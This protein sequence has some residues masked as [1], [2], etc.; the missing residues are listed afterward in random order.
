MSDYISPL[1]LVLDADAL[2]SNYRWLSNESGSA[3]CGAAVK[4]DGYGLGARGVV[5]QLAKAGCRDFFVAT[6]AEA[7]ALGPMHDGLSVA[8]L[9]GVREEDMELALSTPYRPVLNS[10]DQ[11]ERWRQTGRPC[12]IMIDTGM[13]RLGLRASDVWAGLFKGLDI[14]LLMSHMASADEDVDQNIAQRSIFQSMTDQTS[15]RRMSLAN[16]A[17]ILLGDNYHFQLTRPGI[18]LYGGIPRK[19]ARGNIRQ[20]VYPQAQILQR[21]V[22]DRGDLVGY[23]GTYRADCRTE[24]AIINLGYADG[25]LR[26]FSKKGSANGGRLPFIGRVSMDLI[27]LKVDAQPDLVAGD[28]VTLDYDL[29]IASKNTGLSPYELLTGLGPRFDRVWRKSI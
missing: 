17:G 2:K 20:V 28:W 10:R 11:V 27:A 6:W 18:G 22:I 12:D 15:A 7:K 4:A 21:R 23:N 8:V 1:R 29:Q 13:S 16:S 25:I 14:E 24:V 3:K 9:H 26:S 5:D 19:E